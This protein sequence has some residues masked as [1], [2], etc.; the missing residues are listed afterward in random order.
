[1]FISFNINIPCFVQY[2]LYGI[3]HSRLEAKIFQGTTRRRQIST[4]GH[5]QLEIRLVAVNS[6]RSSFLI[7][8]FFNFIVI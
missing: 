8:V 6:S 3:F 5:R 7:V 4:A 1:M 2:N